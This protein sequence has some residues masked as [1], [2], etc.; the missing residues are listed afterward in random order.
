VSW[1]NNH[2][3]TTTFE[4]LTSDKSIWTYIH[5]SGM[6]VKD[7]SEE[8]KTENWVKLTNYTA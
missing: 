2:F 3:Q 7:Y 5:Y 8:R 1:A 4:S 6:L